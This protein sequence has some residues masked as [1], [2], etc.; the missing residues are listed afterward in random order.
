[1][2][3]LADQCSFLTAS[4]AGS[5]EAEHAHKT[6]TQKAREAHEKALLQQSQDIQRRRLALEMAL[7]SQSAD[8]GVSLLMVKAQEELKAKEQD[9]TTAETELTNVKNELEELKKTVEQATQ[10]TPSEQLAGGFV[11]DEQV[12]WTGADAQVPRGS[13]GLVKGAS[14]QGGKKIR[15]AFPNGEWTFPAS[16]LRRVVVTGGDVPAA[17]V[18]DKVRNHDLFQSPSSQA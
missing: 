11:R 10:R 6:A 5:Q 2:A 8:E 14:T 9:K 16:Q 3:V 17:T 13:V 12:T 1:M 4:V 18:G 7:N 15:V